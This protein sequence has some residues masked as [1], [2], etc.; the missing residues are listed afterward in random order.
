[1]VLSGSSGSIQVIRKSSLTFSSLE[2]FSTVCQDRDRSL[3]LMSES[4]LSENAKL[5][6]I[7]C[8]GLGVALE[9]FLLHE[10]ETGALDARHKLIG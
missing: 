1:M 9:D 6:C 3:H 7:P 4:I 5:N 8:I 10:G 2:F